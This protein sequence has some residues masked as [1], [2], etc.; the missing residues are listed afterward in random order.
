MVLQLV[1]VRSR[2]KS[3]VPE[4]PPKDIDVRS[5]DENLVISDV[6]HFTRPM[7]FRAMISK[8]RGLLSRG[9][10]KFSTAAY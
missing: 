1:A 7:T 6:L 5:L 10:R 9:D 3:D 8:S 2:R 4:A